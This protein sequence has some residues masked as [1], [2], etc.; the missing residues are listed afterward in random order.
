MS[1]EV[2]TMSGTDPTKLKMPD[3]DVPFDRAL[4]AAANEIRAKA[5]L[6][7]SEDLTEAA[8]IVLSEI[9]SA[10][11][12]GTGAE[13]APGPSGVAEEAA[14]SAA[15]FMGA[16]L[17]GLF[18]NLKKQGV[19]LDIPAVF[20]RAGF[21]V[22]QWYSPEQQAAI[23]SSGGD[24][25]K[26]LLTIATDHP[27]VREWIDDVQG[28]TAAYVLTR[29]RTYISLLRKEYLLLCQARVRGFES[30]TAE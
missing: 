6:E 14:S 4:V 19:E 9:M 15:C 13:H 22:F 27:N 29:D 10:I 12:K 28:L 26:H 18:I 17:T 11:L 8:I 23:L 5:N 30:R 25:Y 24:L 16:C 2:F 3:P 1:A 7:G 20:T 21:A